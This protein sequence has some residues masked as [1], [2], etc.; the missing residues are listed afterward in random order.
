MLCN[1]HTS[2]SII[3]NIYHKHHKKWERKRKIN[4]ERTK[5]TRINNYNVNEL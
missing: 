5:H 3:R 2:S 1:L 4:K